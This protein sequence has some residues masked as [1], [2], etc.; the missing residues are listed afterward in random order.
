MG[1][2]SGEYQWGSG[3]TSR[4]RKDAAVRLDDR[5]QLVVAVQLEVGDIGR[6]PAV[7]DELVEHLELLALLQLVA[8]GPVAIHGAGEAHA[9]VHAHAVLAHDA[10]Q[11]GL[12]LLKLEARQ[13]AE[14]AEA[15][16]QDGG[17]DA[18]E[19][20]RGEEDGAV[21]AQRQD[22]VELLGLA[23][24]QVGGP[25]LEH[26]VEAGV[27]VGDAAGVE[28]LR[29]AQLGVDI[30]VDAEVGAV[31]RGLE[32]PLGQLAG[33]DDELVVAGLGDDHDV[34]DGAL[35]G[36]ALE[37]L[38][39]LAHAGGGLGEARVR[40]GLVVLD[41]LED[42]VDVDGVV[43]ALVVEA[44]RLQGGEGGGRGG[45]G[46]GARAL[47]LG[48]AIEG[49][50]ELLGGRGGGAVVGAHGG[51]AVGGEHAGER[52]GLGLVVAC[53]RG[54]CFHDSLSRDR[55][56]RERVPLVATGGGGVGGD[57]GEAASGGGGGGG[58]GCCGAR[59]RGGERGRVGG[60]SSGVLGHEVGERR[61]QD[62]SA[63]SGQREGWVG[64][65][66]MVPDCGRRWDE[67]WGGRRRGGDSGRCDRSYGHVL[68]GGGGRWRGRARMP[69]IRTQR[70]RQRRGRECYEEGGMGSG[71]VGEV[72]VGSGG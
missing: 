9:Q 16:G 63:Y 38:G 10:V 2:G 17:H 50:A 7:D 18:L 12:V 44:G 19:E 48:E 56:D 32:Q 6:R 8:A 53:H 3:L 71:S 36:A 27:P 52:E 40:H 67:G 62:R 24:A 54:Q 31:A 26:L 59:G 22:Q 25:V 11:V 15:E 20:P 43:E 4:S 60:I 47:G 68:V 69:R 70:Q 34:A 45:G 28:A 61:R 33:E 35:D 37:L 42:L 66:F 57:R 41:L 23:P 55:L 58:G 64:D 39:D 46:D 29:V 49:I 13:E 65:W 72:R 5:Q 21:A 1:I 51:A 14:A 30:D